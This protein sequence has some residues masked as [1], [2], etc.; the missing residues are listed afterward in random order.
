MGL[1][2]LCGDASASKPVIDA[3]RIVDNLDSSRTFFHPRILDEEKRLGIRQGIPGACRLFGMEGYLRD[4][5]VWSADL[6]NAVRVSGDGTVGAVVEPA[7]YVEAMTC[8][9]ERAY[10][11]KLTVKSIRE[12]PD[13]SV[14]I[15]L[16]EIHNGPRHFPVLSGHTGICRMLG[17]NDAV[18]Y[19]REWST[20]TTR[21]VSVA[22]DGQIYEKASGTH[23]TALACRNGSLKPKGAA[24]SSSLQRTGPEERQME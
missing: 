20:R 4:Y 22:P 6:M 10:Q 11:P 8:T 3:D 1:I 7:R 2:L 21:G 24:G 14:T 16:P 12:N 17:Y 5:V 15:E 9:S 19:S 18:E 23:L 13:G